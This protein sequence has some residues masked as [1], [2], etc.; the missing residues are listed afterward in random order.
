M[1]RRSPV[2][3]REAVMASDKKF[4]VLLAVDPTVPELR[5]T[6][7]S[8][9]WLKRWI[10]EKGAAVHVVFVSSTHSYAEGMSETAF[11]DYVGSL[12][13]GTAVQSKLLFEK[14]T[15]RRKLVTGLNH[16][17]EE[18]KVDLVAIT[19]HGRSALG[20]L[21]FGSF[22]ENLLG[23]SKVPVL[24]LSTVVE[25]V[26]HSNK[27]LFPTD[28]SDYSKASLKLLLQQL[29]GYQGEIILYHAT[30]PAGAAFTAG[31]FGA[32]VYL[33]AT[34]WVEQRQ[35]IDRECELL[36][37]SVYSQGFKVRV[38]IEDGV[39]N[40]PASVQK[41]AEDEKVDLVAMASL[42]RGLDL[43]IMGSV[44]RSLFRTRKTPVWVCG[45]EVVFDRDAKM[46]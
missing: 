22:A 34:Y 6:G 2:I 17:A 18:N 1:G 13:L 44:A 21:V 30:L 8:L 40:I 42:S 11:I 16:Y 20:R 33:P 3:F 7:E 39:L 32:P 38:E 12:G 25:R 5:P 23:T 46:N 37:N 35:L 26:S 41:I 14:G 10:E 15:S 43:A 36:R 29:S 19:S 45:P 27:I 24:F 28:L 4:T 9:F 31:F